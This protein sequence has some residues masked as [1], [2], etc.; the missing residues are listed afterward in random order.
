M[1]DLFP[2]FAEEHIY[3]YTLKKIGNLPSI[4]VKHGKDTKLLNVHHTTSSSVHSIICVLGAVPSPRTPHSSVH[5]AQWD[6]STAE[7]QINVHLV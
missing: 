7:L 4:F 6:A 5:A 3:T 2:I 1:H